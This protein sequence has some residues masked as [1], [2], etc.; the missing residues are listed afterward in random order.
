VAGESIDLHPIQIADLD[1]AKKALGF[2]RDQ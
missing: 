1:K 2:P